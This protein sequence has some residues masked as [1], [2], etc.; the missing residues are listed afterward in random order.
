MV[1][2]MAKKTGNCPCMNCGKEQDGRKLHP[3]TVWHKEEGEK[4]GHNCP[5]CSIECA[6]EYSK[7]F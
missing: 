6:N 7:R 3:F 1:K 4:R 5:V 2:I